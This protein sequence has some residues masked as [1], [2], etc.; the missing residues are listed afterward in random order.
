MLFDVFL[1]NIEPV[2]DYV[3]PIRSDSVAA[4]QQFEDG[5]ID[6]LYLDASHTYKGV[7]AD[8]RA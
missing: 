3:K 1:H 6:F 2:A 4:A 5:S 7:L 8:L